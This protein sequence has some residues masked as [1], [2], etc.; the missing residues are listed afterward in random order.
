MGMNETQCSK[1]SIGATLVGGLD[2]QGLYEFLHGQRDRK[3]FYINSSHF[4]T[5]RAY[6]IKLQIVFC[7]T[8]GHGFGAHELIPFG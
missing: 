8:L 4:R 7:F 1:C 3:C 5:E 2:T 6:E